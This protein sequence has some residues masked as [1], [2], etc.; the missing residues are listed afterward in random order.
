MAD[1]EAWVAETPEYLASVSQAHGIGA[2]NRCAALRSLSPAP[3]GADFAK[4]PIYLL[5][6]DANAIVPA[7]HSRD[8]STSLAVLSES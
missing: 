1:F 4:I 6:G 7:H 5:P 2:E 3:H 8:F